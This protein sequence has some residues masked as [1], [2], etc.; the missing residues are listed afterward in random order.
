[1]NPS[2]SD[3]QRLRF[4]VERYE[5]LKGLRLV[6]IGGVYTVVFGVG[7]AAAMNRMFAE[8]WTVPALILITVPL[9]FCGMYI[10]DRYYVMRFGRVRIGRVGRRAMFAATP[11]IISMLTVLGLRASLG[12]VPCLLGLGGFWLWAAIRD[13]SFRRHLVIGVFAAWAAACVSLASGAPG[14]DHAVMS[15]FMTAGVASIAI[16]LLD[17]R[18]LVK[19]LPGL[20][21][22]E[23]TVP[24]DSDAA[25]PGGS[26]VPD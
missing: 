1:M 5:E 24:A 11:I 10:V 13:W 21:R 23:T 4:V 8:S 17:H 9:V 2:A 14:S 6:V 12:M 26:A 15:A 19:T 3:V 20:D 16:G 22:N 25:S 7:R 18:L